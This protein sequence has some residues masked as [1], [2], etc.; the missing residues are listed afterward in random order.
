MKYYLTLGSGREVELEVLEQGEVAGRRIPLHWRLALPQIRRELSV[1]ALL[2]EQ[3]M[4]VDFPY[5][6]GAVRVSGD[7]PANNG[8]GYLEMTGYPPE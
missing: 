6:E 7:G 3:W 1:E 8:V 2:A 4:E 5:W